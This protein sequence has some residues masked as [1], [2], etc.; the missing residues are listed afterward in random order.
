MGLVK[1]LSQSIGAGYPK[2]T[3]RLK[4]VLGNSETPPI[5]VAFTGDSTVDN[6]R[7]VDGSKSYGEKSNTVTHQTAEALA[8][9]PGSYFIGNFAVDG[10]TTDDLLSYCS[11]GK[12]LTDEDHIRSN[13]VHQLKAVTAWKPDVVVLSV[14]GN[15]YREALADTL[16]EEMNYP[17]LLL[18][19]T[20]EDAK[21]AIHLAFEQVKA[22]I[23]KD[24]KKI[25][26]ELIDKNPQ[27]SRIVLLSQ[28]YPSITQLTPYFI[29]TGFSHLARAE[30]KGRAPFA[31]VEETMNELYRDILAYAA[32]QEKEIVFVDTTSSLNP[33]GGKHAFQI[34]PNEQGSGIMGRLIA[35][36]IEYQFPGTKSEHDE[37]FIPRIYL[38]ADEKQIQAQVLNKKDI[39]AFRVK[40][41]GQFISDNR[42][43]HLRLLFSPSSS[44]T[45][46]FESAYHAITGK[47]FDDEYTGLPAF[48][49]LD[50]T[51]VP[52][53]ATYLWRVAV[54]E[55]V[56]TSLRAIA[57]SVAA[58]I[59]LSKTVL[60]LS[61]ML[62]LSL[63]LLGYDK[64]VH[65]IAKQNTEGQEENSESNKLEV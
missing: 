6:G 9:T 55:N 29:Y 44:L 50:L 48:G 62:A 60:G 30:G 34:E 15:N 12:V 35:S 20:P 36:A 21:P 27:L 19:I 65:C 57:G 43:R 54:N 41:I 13:S 40:S 4:Q 42:Y 16:M 28:Y 37:Q 17:Q 56:H 33:L 58:P 5:K 22:N 14:G 64:A 24:Y 51:L 11:L 10:A 25:I 26:D 46:R 49:L 3:G 47:Q 53:M 31:V 7:W 61:L 63:P 59:L 32:T 23:L 2:N 8:H 38:S 52:V 18:R 1:N 45:V 39:E